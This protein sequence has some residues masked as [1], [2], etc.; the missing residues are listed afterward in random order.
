MVKNQEIAV[1]DEGLLV[2][3]GNSILFA[4]YHL[5]T[6]TPTFCAFVFSTN[7]LRP[8]LTTG[9]GWS[10]QQFLGADFCILY[11]ELELELGTVIGME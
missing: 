8:Q 5:I 10:G 1:S 4:G 11:Y 3:G 6:A 7:D 2:V 9:I